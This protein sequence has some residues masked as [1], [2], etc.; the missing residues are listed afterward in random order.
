MTPTPSGALSSVLEGVVAKPR[1][2]AYR[3]GERGW[4]K[5][6]SRAYWK[7]DLERE[8][9][10]SERRPRVVSRTSQSR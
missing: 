1:G 3:P 2:S 10:V 7:Y 6:K 4:L 8:F 9:V 5:I